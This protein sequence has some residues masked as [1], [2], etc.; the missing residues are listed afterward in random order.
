MSKSV[1]I[2]FIDTEEVISKDNLKDYAPEGGH[3]SLEGYKKVADLI[4]RKIIN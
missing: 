3:L 2:T 4:S 1:G